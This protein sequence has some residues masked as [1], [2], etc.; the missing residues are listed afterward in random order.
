MV[1]VTIYVSH[2]EDLL[3][4]KSDCNVPQCGTGGSAYLPV[5]AFPKQSNDGDAK[6]ES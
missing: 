3:R 1:N 6:D 2:S 5:S 4:R